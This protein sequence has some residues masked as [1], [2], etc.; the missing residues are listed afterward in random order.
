MVEPEE[1]DLADMV[2]VDPEE[3]DLADM[4]DPEEADPEEADLAD[5]VDPEEADLADMVDPDDADL[6]DMADPD[7]ADLADMVELESDMVDL[8]ES[9]LL[10]F[11]SFPR[12]TPPRPSAE[13]RTMAIVRIAAKI[14]NFIVL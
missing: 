9:C 13:P 12:T 3:A 2:M 11:L 5:M 6:A 8:E 7:D 1:A 10:P 4:V 14:L